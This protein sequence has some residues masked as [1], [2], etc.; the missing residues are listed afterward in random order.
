MSPS[1][2]DPRSINQLL[3]SLPDEEYKRIAPHLKHVNLCQGQ[4]LYERG[5]VIQQVYFPTRSMVSLICVLSNNSI[6]EFALVGNEG[7]IGIPAFLGGQFTNNR[8]IVQ[9]ADG[10]LTMDAEIL[11]REFER[12]GVLQ[13]KLLLYTQALVTQISQ[14]AVCKSHHS[15]EQQLAR[16]LLCVQDCLGRDE[17]FLTQQYIADLMGTRRA[18]I[19]VAAGSLQQEGMIRY[20][21]GKIVILNR[22]ALEATACEC[23]DIVKNEFARLLSF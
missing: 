21:R 13:K 5:E 8:A 12:G 14:N 7:I 16:W 18:T 9:I 15:I 20:S 4:I 22:A 11:Q 3:A 19:T 1:D 17:I 2:S 23:Y 10:A 6:T